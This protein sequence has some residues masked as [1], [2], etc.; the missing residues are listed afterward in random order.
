MIV[1]CIF[2]TMKLSNMRAV[3]LAALLQIAARMKAECHL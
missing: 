3:T 1:A 2:K